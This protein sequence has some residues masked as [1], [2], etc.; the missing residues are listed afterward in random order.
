[1]PPVKRAMCPACASAPSTPTVLQAHH[2]L[3]A[4]VP[5]RGLA[6]LVTAASAEEEAMLPGEAAALYARAAG[7]LESAGQLAEAQSL[8]EREAACRRAV[9]RRN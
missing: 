7:L 9:Q 5:Q 2:W 1:L 3:A 6:L 8:R 4:G